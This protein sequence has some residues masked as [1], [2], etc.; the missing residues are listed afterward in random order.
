MNPITHSES[1]NVRRN[2][3][4]ASTKLTLSAAAI[5]LLAGKDVLAAGASGASGQDVAILNVALALEHE[6][7]NAY[8][9]G[10]QSGLLAKPVLDIAVAFQGHHKSHRDALVA[11]IQ[12]LGGS[13]V[14]EKSLDAYAKQLQADRIRNQGDILMLAQRLELGAANAY[15]SVIPALQDKELAKIAARLAADE[16]MHWTALSGALGTILPAAALSFGA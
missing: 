4:T 11:T 16:T 13:A 15:L 1:T 14:Q 12:K 2:F 7:I 6:A 5:A 10:A 9:L 3:L 8:T